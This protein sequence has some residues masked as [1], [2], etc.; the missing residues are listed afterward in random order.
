ML[1]RNLKL[2][3]YILNLNQIFCLVLVLIVI[4][5]TYNKGIDLTDESLFY[6]FSNPNVQNYHSII[7]YDLIFKLIYKFFNF[8]FSI[9][10][11]RI[12]RFFLTFLVFSILIFYFKKF[13]F[14]FCE[15]LLLLISCFAGYSIMPQTLSYYPLTFFLIFVFVVILYSNLNKFKFYKIILIGFLLA[16]EYLIKPPTAL[17][18]LLLIIF[19]SIKLY[20]ESKFLNSFLLVSISFFSFFSTLCFFHKYFFDFSFLN[21]FKDSLEFSKSCLDP[22]HSTKFI[23]NTQISSF[24]WSILLIVSGYTFGKFINQKK[25]KEFY[26]FISLILFLYFFLSHFIGKKFDFVDYGLVTLCLFTIGFSINFCK[27]INIKSN[28]IILYLLLFTAPFICNIGSNVYFFR[29]GVHYIVFWIL[30]IILIN[31]KKFDKNNFIYKNF[32]ILFYTLL[33]LIGVYKNLILYPCNYQPRLNQNLYE[34]IYDKNKKIYLP[35][36][37]MNYLSELRTKLN[38]LRDKENNGF[39]I[40][41]YKMPGDIIMS[42]MKI[43]YNPLTWGKEWIQFYF[44]K[45]KS[46][47]NFNSINPLIISDN[48]KNYEIRKYFEITLV[49]SLKKFNKYI[50]IYKSKT[51]QNKIK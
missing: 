18:G 4:A 32:F 29:V 22:T 12:I 7:R 28:I 21:V 23:I 8:R 13:K 40:G 35:S 20:F 45:A 37:Y 9:S 30:L 10:D 6:C 15:K 3:D 50:Y 33:V 5:W 24:K 17:I 42:D 14:S 26:L 25:N 38:N 19:F 51:K 1:N 44:D 31:G 16:L 48:K 36:S 34:F 43:Y 46:E 49:D 2:F 11:L 47:N 41:L 39:V 27:K